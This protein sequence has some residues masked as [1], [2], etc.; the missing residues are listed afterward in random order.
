[1][2]LQKTDNMDSP[3]EKHQKTKGA[4]ITNPF[5]LPEAVDNSINEDLHL[6]EEY[7]QKKIRGQRERTLIIFILGAGSVAIFLTLDALA[8]FSIIEWIKAY[9][10]YPLTLMMAILALVALAQIALRRW[11]GKAPLAWPSTQGKVT[12]F[13]A[14]QKIKSGQRASDDEEYR[15]SAWINYQYEH[16]GKNY[17]GT[18]TLIP[19]GF[20]TGKAYLDILSFAR[21][22]PEG[23]PLKIF[24]HPQLVW[25]SSPVDV[26]PPREGVWMTIL[27]ASLGGAILFWLIGV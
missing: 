25:L 20:D 14:T 23:K 18:Y 19:V 1:M 10:A 13:S 9:V 4:K 24:H 16:N 11:I 2:D 3:G 26:P 17:S 5:Y 7:V 21:R 8:D 27:I 22:F 12:R 15:W 6:W